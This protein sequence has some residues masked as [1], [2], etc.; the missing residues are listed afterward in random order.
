MIF[1]AILYYTIIMDNIDNKIEG[2][3]SLFDINPTNKENDLLQPIKD[4]N[5]M[6]IVNDSQSSNQSVPL[7]KKRTRPQSD[8]ESNEE[9][10]E[11][12]VQ[13]MDESMPLT[14]KPSRVRSV[15]GNRSRKL[16]RKK[17]H[18]KKTKRNIH[19]KK[20][21]SS[22]IKHNKLKHRQKRNTRRKK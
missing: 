8:D 22:T 9:S 12:E 16:K 5:N 18:L 14:K 15:G 1:N 3:N 20:R 6:D 7:T 21:T 13:S 19:P 10:N 17:L 11:E 4:E 2:D